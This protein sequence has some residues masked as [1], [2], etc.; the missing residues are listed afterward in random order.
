NGNYHGTP[1]RSVTVLEG[2]RQ[3]LGDGVRL[4]YSE[5][6]HLF[7]D[8]VEGLALPGD[9][10]A[11]AKAAAA[12]SDVTVLC[13]GLDETMEGE[14]GDTS[15]LSASGDKLGLD[16]PPAQQ[17]LLEAVVST[18]KPVILVMLA[19]SALNLSYAQE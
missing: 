11:E 16:L 12:L 10:L 17:E 6:S 5:G 3:E 15:N 18:G 19:G 7:K 4:F 1:S 2:L 9:R 14:Q 13:L 8:R